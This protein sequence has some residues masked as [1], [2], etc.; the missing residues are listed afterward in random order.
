M[1]VEILEWFSLRELAIC[2]WQKTKNLGLAPSRG[3]LVEDRY[4]CICVGQLLDTSW[5][6]L[7]T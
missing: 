3:P 2:A 5:A 7:E 4:T 1:R 6:K